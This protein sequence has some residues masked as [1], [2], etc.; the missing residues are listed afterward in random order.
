MPVTRPEADTSPVSLIS[1][2][3]RRGARGHGAARPPLSA[4]RW[5]HETLAGAVCLAALP[6][7]WVGAPLLAS[8]LVTLSLA[9]QLRSL[10]GRADLHQRAEAGA[11]LEQRLALLELTLQSE[12]EQSLRERQRVE[13]KARH[14]ERLRERMDELRSS[15]EG[16]AEAVLRVDDEGR[17]VWLNA[18]AQR[19]TGWRAEEVRDRHCLDVLTLVDAC[20]R[21][22]LADP[23]AVTL[24]TGRPTTGEDDAV[25]VRRDGTE[26]DVEY[27]ASPVVPPPGRPK[28]AVL[29]LRDVTARR[30]EQRAL[31]WRASHDHLTE[32]LNRAEFERRLRRLLASR[33]PEQ[34][35]HVLCCIDLDNFKAVN[36]SCGHA[37]GDQLL[38]G[39]ARLL[40]SCIRGA[41]TLARL[42]GDEFAV[43]LHRCPLERALIL[44]E[45]IRR[46][47]DEHRFDWQGTPL[48]VGASIGLVAVDR[49]WNDLAEVTAAA[50]AAC[51]AAKA[52][53]RNRVHVYRP[54]LDGDGARHG[55]LAA[56]RRLQDAIERDAV[57][58]A[59]EVLTP[60]HPLVPWRYVEA[61]ARLSGRDVPESC[62]LRALARHYHLEQA[63]D[64][65]VLRQAVLRLEA[66]EP[67]CVAPAL[68]AVQIGAESLADDRFPG[69][70]LELLGRGG[71]LYQ[72]ICF[73][74]A[75]PTLRAHADRGRFL[76]ATLAN[77][78]ARFTLAEF[79]GGPQSYLWLKKLPLTFVKIDP[80]FVRNAPVC[81][82]D[83][84][85]LLGITRAARAADVRVIADG[86]AD[87][88]TFECLR[89]IGVDLLREPAAT[90][91]S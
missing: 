1:V 38:V 79:G 53:G 20:L 4:R 81:G 11:R 36:D 71:G 43:L 12:R 24:A 6:A 62:E 91:A 17:V 82:I 37:A 41:D 16:M 28:G 88:A 15:L 57:Q 89:R 72:R 32:L 34:A 30:R 69:F 76:I 58:L 86:V 7:F 87:A 9:L 40:R 67:P 31:E 47:V 22:P 50:D 26:F 21:Q 65:C 77:H 27:Q 59:L 56:L 60:A 75:E 44:A 54:E 29:V 8:I 70:L 90:A 46:A 66:G 51:Y 83:Q 74:L 85:V 78:G 33:G 13:S 73:E 48:R 19:L 3:D 23:V 18:A 84:E 52:A 45:G 63:L 2:A 42:A 68:L 14:I 39:I 25:L 61:R 55:D 64:R 49:H 10:R 80:R 5:S 35:I